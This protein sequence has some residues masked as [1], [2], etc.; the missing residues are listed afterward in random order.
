MKKKTFC[1]NCHKRIKW[2]YIW[3]D[4][5]G[6]WYEQTCFDC[7]IKINLKCT[8]SNKLYKEIYGFD[9]PKK[10]HFNRKSQYCLKF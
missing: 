7:D 1:P 2:T 3:K 6:I 8:M 4:S 5:D 10:K 9:K